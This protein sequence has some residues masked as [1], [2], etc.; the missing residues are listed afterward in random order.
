M[1]PILQLAVCPA[2]PFFDVGCQQALHRRAP[3]LQNG[4]TDENHEGSGRNDSKGHKAK[5][6]LKGPSCHKGIFKLMMAGWLLLPSWPKALAVNS[7]EEARATGKKHH[8]LKLARAVPEGHHCDDDNCGIS[9]I[10]GEWECECSVMLDARKPV[11][12]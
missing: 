1:L 11:R 12:N 2:G 8:S 7:P 3:E 9:G 6:S 4:E 5:T 10:S